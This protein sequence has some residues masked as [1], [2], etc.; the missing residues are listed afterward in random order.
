M[1]SPY[2]LVEIYIFIW[3]NIN[4]EEIFDAMEKI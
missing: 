4:D 3:N 1:N 2:F